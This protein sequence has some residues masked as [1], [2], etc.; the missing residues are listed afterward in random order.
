MHRAGPRNRSFGDTAS[1]HQHTTKLLWTIKRECRQPYSVVSRTFRDAKI[2][3]HN[4]G[5]S[6]VSIIFIL[7]QGHDKNMVVCTTSGIN[8]NMGTNVQGIPI[9]I[10]SGS[11]NECNPK[12]DVVVWIVQWGFVPQ[13]L[14]VR[15]ASICTVPTDRFLET[16]SQE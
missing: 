16:L 10:L 9:G 11:K 12:G 15:Q 7:A 3:K 2:C 13:V 8:Q 4:P 14:R 5:A 1:Y 6:A